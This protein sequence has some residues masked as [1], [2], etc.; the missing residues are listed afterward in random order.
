MN[1]LEKDKILLRAPEPEDV[2]FLYQMEND[3]RL[4]HLSNTLTP[5]SRFDL[6]QFILLPDKDIYITKQARFIIDYKDD[7]VKTAGAVDLFDF[8]PQHQRAG[9]GI[10]VLESFRNRGI[11]ATA[12]E[13]LMQYAFN[14]L[15]LY[16]LYCNIE[17]DNTVSLKLFQKMGFEICGKK[18]E[19]NRRGNHRVNEYMLQLI[20]HR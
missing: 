6:E 12:L 10:M 1:R 15:G 9:V 19:W 8:K 2:D 13:I 14:H 3:Q 17:E 5:F 4:W 18:M 16:Q 20:N 7:P 11:A